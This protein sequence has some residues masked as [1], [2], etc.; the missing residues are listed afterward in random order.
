MIIHL[1]EE[2]LEYVLFYLYDT[3]RLSVT[4]TS[5]YFYQ[6]KMKNR[7]IDDWMTMGRCKIVRTIVNQK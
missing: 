2:I 3:D 1:P 5:K 4:K 6:S 7:L